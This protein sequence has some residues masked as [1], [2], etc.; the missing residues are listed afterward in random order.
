M[1]MGLGPDL[2]LEATVNPD[3]GQVEADP[4]EVNLS[5]LET[6]FPE[7]RPFFLEDSR[8]LNTSLANNFFN[9]RRIGA[10]PTAPV[11]ADYVDYPQTATILTAAKLTGRLVSGTSIGILGAMTGEEF[12]HTAQRARINRQSTRC[13]AGELGTGTRS[14]G[15]RTVRVNYQ[16]NVYCGSSRSQTGGSVG[17]AVEP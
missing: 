8:L 2:T 15:V 7:K 13:S 9:S 16:R 4:A 17:C 14:A 1:K 5:A 12:A 3:F 10:P 11:S 6:F